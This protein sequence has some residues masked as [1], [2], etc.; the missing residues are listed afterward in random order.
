MFERRTELRNTRNTERKEFALTL[1]MEA[2]VWTW[3]L[4]M[5]G[6]AG[7]CQYISRDMKEKISAR[8]K[9]RNDVST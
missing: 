2:E 9:D 7:H 3:I 8:G 6:S 4:K 1:D 5:C